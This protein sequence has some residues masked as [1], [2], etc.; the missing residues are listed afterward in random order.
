MVETIISP[1]AIIA[2]S[3]MLVH[4]TQEGHKGS[5]P[6]SIHFSSKSGLY[7]ITLSLEKRD[8]LYYCPTNTFT[9]NR[10]PS[11]PA[12]P[13]IKRATTPPQPATPCCS[14]RYFPVMQDHMAE[15]EVWFLC[16]GCP[17]EDQLDLLLGNVTG[18][19]PGFQYHPFQFIDWKEEA[20]IQ[21]Q[22]AL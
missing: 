3:N 11:C 20:H 2:A 10:D 7:S 17:S 8:G 21:K 19:P 14:R 16:I 22:T 1:E 5:D 12:I 15:F 6:G 18:I 13:L 9:I 4:W